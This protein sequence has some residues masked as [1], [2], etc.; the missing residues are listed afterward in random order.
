VR[1]NCSTSVGGG[2]LLTLHLDACLQTRLHTHLVE[3]EPLTFVPLI[4][5]SLMLYCQ[6]LA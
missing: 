4:D 3:T 1:G 6:T 2:E 5:E